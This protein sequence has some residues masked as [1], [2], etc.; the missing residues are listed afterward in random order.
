M[1]VSLF[2]KHHYVLTRFVEQEVIH[3]GMNR[4]LKRNI[5][6][7][8]GSC[9]PA[10]HLFIGRNGQKS[11]VGPPP[12]RAVYPAGYHSLEFQCL[13]SAEGNHYKQHQSLQSRYNLTFRAILIYIH[14]GGVQQRLIGPLRAD[15]E[16]PVFG[17][18]VIPAH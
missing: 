15:L 2:S 18:W 14:I 7:R 9:G 13:A 3:C 5:S 17:L 11:I 10:Y 12:P 8:V 4:F 16:G 1:G 6:C